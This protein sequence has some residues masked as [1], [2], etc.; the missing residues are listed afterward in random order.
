MNNPTKS[1][2][3]P[4][5]TTEEIRAMKEQ[6]RIDSV[7]PEQPVSKRA[8]YTSL[9]Y[10]VALVS[11]AVILV[12]L[13]YE[14]ILVS[15]L[16]GAIS[17][18]LRDI[19]NSSGFLSDFLT[20]ALNL[21]VFALIAFLFGFALDI[22][23]S[24]KGRPREIW[25]KYIKF[26]LPAAFGSCIVYLLIRHLTTGASFRVSGSILS[27]ILYYFTM[28]VIVPAGNVL[29]YLVLPSSAIRML[30]TVVSDTK[31]RAELPL[32]IVSTAVMTIA[33]LGVTPRHI[34]N[35]GL[36]VAVFA[37]IQSA[38]CSLLYR[39]TN[40]IRYTILLYSGV[41]ALYLAL[42]PVLNRLM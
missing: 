40:V 13:Y 31:E 9:N 3:K 26:I 6:E 10:A 18:Y 38:A 27:Q 5:M 11:G 33:M 20:G 4:A 30:L 32:T 14:S 39:R 12:A 17:E 19:D 29:L 8:L 23:Y 25:G 7:L 28:I 35:Y 37:L 34:E 41:S 2:E 24:G 1:E 21:L 15:Y 36:P 42:A 22:N 16:R